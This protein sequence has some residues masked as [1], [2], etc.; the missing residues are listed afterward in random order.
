MHFS[1]VD[2]HA[3]GQNVNKL[4]TCVRIKHIPTGIFVKCQQERSQLQNK[5]QRTAASL[6]KADC[7]SF[8]DVQRI[9]STCRSIYRARHCQH[10]AP[11]TT[12]ISYHVQGSL[13]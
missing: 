11:H 8:G 12:F 10:A 6:H 3:G 13:V 4:E 2:V 5:V 9:V 7:Q 1:S